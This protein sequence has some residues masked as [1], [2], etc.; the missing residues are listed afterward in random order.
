MEFLAFLGCFTFAVFFVSLIRALISLGSKT[1]G[2]FTVI[3]YKDGK[4]VYQETIVD[5]SYIVGPGSRFDRL[6][7]VG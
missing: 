4:V 6:E 5:S 7:I 3:G 1:K 2:S